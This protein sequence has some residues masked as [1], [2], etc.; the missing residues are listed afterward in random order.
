M[1]AQIAVDA[2]GVQ[3]SL[4]MTI[5]M[6]VVGMEMRS[7]GRMIQNVFHKSQRRVAF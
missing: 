4:F 1:A 3:A 7:S 2:D 5:R 6:G